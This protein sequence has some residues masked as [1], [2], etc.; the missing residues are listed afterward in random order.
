MRYLRGIDWAQL[1]ELANG[2]R[3]IT[4]SSLLIWGERDPFFPPERAREMVDQ[5]RDCRGFVVVPAT[6]LL[7]HEEQPAVVADHILRFFEGTGA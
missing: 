7:P 2:H 6:R 3:E 4:G 5:F 1:D